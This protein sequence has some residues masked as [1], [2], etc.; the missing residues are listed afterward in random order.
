M[1]NFHVVLVAAA[2]VGVLLLIFI[3]KKKNDAQ[4]GQGF[5]LSADETRFLTSNVRMVENVKN[6]ASF[7]LPRLS[8]GRV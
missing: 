5:Y 8:G 2:A 3:Y 6:F 7:V 1:E 4:E